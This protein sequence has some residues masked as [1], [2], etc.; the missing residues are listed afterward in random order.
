[1]LQEGEGGGEGDGRV[2]KSF[3]DTVPSSSGMGRGRG[4]GSE[5]GSTVSH[6]RA[7]GTGCVQCTSL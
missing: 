5:K 3:S 6:V 2:V 4:G 1:M 7:V